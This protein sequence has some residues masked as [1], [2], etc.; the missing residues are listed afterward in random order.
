VAQL[1]GCSQLIG[2]LAP[3][4]TTVLTENARHVAAQQL[5]STVRETTVV[6]DRLRL[7]PEAA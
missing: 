4:I 5:R 1:F 3:A 2:R 7:T 6:A